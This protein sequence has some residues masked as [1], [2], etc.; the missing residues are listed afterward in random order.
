LILDQTK[1]KSLH[2]WGGAGAVF[3]GGSCYRTKLRGFSTAEKW[4]TSKK[5]TKRSHLYCCCCWRKKTNTDT[6][7]RDNDEGAA[8]M[9]GQ[10]KELYGSVPC[11]WFVLQEREIMQHFYY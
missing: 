6:T 5:G 9:D 1:D 2:G 11:F 10:Q 4:T 8:E 3:F 7:T